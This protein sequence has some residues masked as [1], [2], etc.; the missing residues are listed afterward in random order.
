MRSFEERLLSDRW[1]EGKRRRTYWNIT[2]FLGLI[3]VVGLF[4][5][6]LPPVLNWIPFLEPLDDSAD[7]LTATSIFATLILT[8]ALISVY[9]DIGMIQQEQVEEMQSQRDLQ[10]DVVHL[11]ERQ[12]EIMERQEEWMEIGHRP[13]IN[14]ERWQFAGNEVSFYLR[15]VGNGPA[16][17]LTARVV[18][19]G[20]RTF[21]E[22]LYEGSVRLRPQNPS[23]SA[24]ETGVLPPDTEP[25]A[26]I[27]EVRFHGGNA[28]R[29]VLMS[30]F[31]SLVSEM[32]DT[33][34]ESVGYMVFIEYQMIDGEHVREKLWA[35]EAEISD[36]TNLDDLTS[37][38]YWQDLEF[39]YIPPYEWT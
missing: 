33:G 26:F 27:G 14:V 22:I 19:Y 29:P 12:T 2:R 37:D 30:D 25:R 17:D 16:T 21:E 35:A 36:T 4:Y 7:Y 28:N 8:F 6:L 20:D 10:A 15:N 18:I 31:S 11:Q 3:V 39:D 38:M 1:Q 23:S 13:H 9:R 32:V 24:I 34:I 5:F